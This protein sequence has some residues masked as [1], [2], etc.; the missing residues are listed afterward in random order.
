MHMQKLHFSR[1]S[2]KHSRFPR[3]LEGGES[4]HEV[5]RDL[6]ASGLVGV[7]WTEIQS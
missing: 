7:S 3:D 4:T 2:S 5:R 6:L 1:I